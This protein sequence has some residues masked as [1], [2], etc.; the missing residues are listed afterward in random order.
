MRTTTV[1]TAILAL[2]GFTVSGCGGNLAM[3]GTPIV[4]FDIKVNVTD[5]DGKPVGGIE[6]SVLR[7]ADVPAGVIII[8]PIDEPAYEQYLIG[9]GKTDSRGIY[10]LSDSETGFSMGTITVTAKDVDGAE[11][12]EFAT[13]TVTR[14]SSDF[15]FSDDNDGSSWTV[16]NYSPTIDL[17]LEPKAAEQQIAGGENGET[18]EPENVE[19]KVK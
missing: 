1:I 16:G 9:E 12:G 7:R 19:S 5:G 2:L 11:N 18:A 17:S 4:N 3:Y 13:K 15:N 8:D 14:R 6:V 10:T